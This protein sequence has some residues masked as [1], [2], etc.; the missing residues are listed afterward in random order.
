ML[1]DVISSHNCFERPDI[2]RICMPATAMKLS[3]D[4]SFSCVGGIQDRINQENYLILKMAHFQWPVASS[5][6]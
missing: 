2:M 6:S 1:R 4:K 3:I 5:Y